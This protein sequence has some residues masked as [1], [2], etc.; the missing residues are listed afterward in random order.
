MLRSS[1]NKDFD[2]LP[3]NKKEKDAQLL[4]KSSNKSEEAP[5]EEG[6]NPRSEE[7]P[8]LEDEIKIESNFPG[9][10]ITYG[11]EVIKRQAGNSK[12]AVE[13]L[14][15]RF[16]FTPHKT[17]KLAET[18]IAYAQKLSKDCTFCIE[19]TERSRHLRFTNQH[20]LPMSPLQK[21]Y[22]D[23]AHFESKD[24]LVVVDGFSSFI[25]F[26]QVRS[27]ASKALFKAFLKM[28]K[29]FYFP[30]TIVMDNGMNG[31][32]LITALAEVGTTCQFTM[33]YRSNQNRCERAIR[34]FKDTIRPLLEGKLTLTDLAAHNASLKMNFF[35]EVR[36]DMNMP[37]MAH[38]VKFWPDP[39][40][41]AGLPTNSDDS[42]PIFTPTNYKHR[43]NMINQSNI[44]LELKI[45]KLNKK[46]KKIFKP[47]D[48]VNFKSHGK[49]YVKNG[50]NVE[51]G[52][53]QEIMGTQ[54]K[55]LKEGRIIY[56]HL[57]DIFTY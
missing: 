54:V 16:H 32:E 56:R 12:K 27:L 21:V 25:F 53:I 7:D 33:P 3:M 57:E 42:Q 36:D 48:F 5:E 46:V 19:N 18:E 44:N 26:E 2:S 11:Q 8:Y 9:D 29:Y 45:K 14:H 34:T 51:S 17:A 31:K 15:N 40:R 6:S 35:R 47:G 28:F 23:I 1:E 39:K 55:I 37:P 50:K 30:N 24:Y 49:K 41:I 52:Q 13:H 22:A 4:K 38:I 10:L 20:I 43:F